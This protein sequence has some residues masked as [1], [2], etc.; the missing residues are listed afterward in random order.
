MNKLETLTV[1]GA[2]LAAT[3]IAGVNPAEITEALVYDGA[4]GGKLPYR[5][6]VSEGIAEGEKVPLVIFLH[7]AGE[8]GDNN[9]SQLGNGVDSVLNYAI[10]RNI[11]FA[12]IIPQCPGNAQWV[13]TPWDQLAHRMNAEPSAPMKLLIALLGEKIN[14]LPID[15]ARIYVTGLSMGGYGTWDLCQRF[16]DKIAAAIPNCGGGDTTLA[17]KIRD[18]PIWAFHGS[19]DTVVPTYRS[20]AMVSAL[21]EVNGN[22]RYHEY[23]GVGHGCWGATYANTEVLDWLFSQKKQ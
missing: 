17:W 21:W 1:G 18:V 22:I 19:A 16:P 7:G 13:D 12:M 11:H 9:V 14:E 5:Q 10:D 4:E 15:T 6:Y 3:A 23:P 20:R 2:M 8:R